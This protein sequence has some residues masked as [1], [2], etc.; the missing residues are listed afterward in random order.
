MQHILKTWPAPFGAVWDGAKACEI[1]KDDRGYSV[2]DT[3]VLREFDPAA[4]GGDPERY[5]GREI[6][7]TVTWLARGPEWGLP[8]GMV[9]MSLRVEF[10]R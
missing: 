5:S 8:E 7:A 3:L 10:R 9:V 4:P 6:G 1:R 2:G